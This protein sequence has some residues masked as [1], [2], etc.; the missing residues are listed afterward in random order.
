MLERVT[1]IHP[2]T[3]T[4][5]NSNRQV[6]T[7]P[8]PCCCRHLSTNTHLPSIVRNE[9]ITHASSCPVVMMF[10][11]WVASPKT[12]ENLTSCRAWSTS[13]WKPKPGSSKPTWSFRA[14]ISAP[15]E[16][17]AHLLAIADSRYRDRFCVVVGRTV[18]RHRDFLFA[19]GLMAWLHGCVV[20]L[21]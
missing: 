3:S 11:A 10:S 4:S 5:Y 15:G 9:E 12:T 18:M 8:P 14:R 13:I 2:P 21:L 20:S 16:W 19:L 1:P 6:L 7:S 17:D